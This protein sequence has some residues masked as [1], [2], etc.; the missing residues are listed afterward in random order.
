[1]N[2]ISPRLRE[3]IIADK[4]ERI[5]SEAVRLF[6]ENGYTATTL[7]EV[8][9]ALGVTKPYIYAYFRGKIQLLSACCLPVIQLSCAAMEQAASSQGSA[10]ERLS[11]AVG[12]FTKMVLQYQANIAVFFR[13]E[14]HLP[15][16]VRAEIEALRKQFDRRLSDLLA[17]GTAAGEFAV[18]ETTLISLALSGMICW[19]YTWYRAK[20]RLDPAT[21][22]RQMAAIALRM[23]GARQQA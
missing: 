11:R 13:E 23:V 21:M 3:E 17:E 15:D 2:H 20:G 9:A 19:I 4:R 16:D 18:D 7:D 22:S 10:T 5:L 6:Y 1:M 8:A 12:D 14:K